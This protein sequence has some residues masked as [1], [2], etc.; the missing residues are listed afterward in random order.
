MVAGHISA[1]VTWRVHAGGIPDDDTAR[2]AILPEA[3]ADQ[4]DPHEGDQR[5]DPLV[6]ELADTCDHGRALRPQRHE[7]MR[8]DERGKSEHK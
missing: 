6:R 3:I 8:P 5:H 4:D 2:R 7:D 1:T